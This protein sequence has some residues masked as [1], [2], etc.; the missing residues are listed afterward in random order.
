MGDEGV[1]YIEYE[2]FCDYFNDVNF[3]HLLDKPTYEVETFEPDAVHGEIFMFNV[4][5]AGFYII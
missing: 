2:E 5:V 3:C 1:F 4:K